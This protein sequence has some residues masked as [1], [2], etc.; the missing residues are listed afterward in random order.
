LIKWESKLTIET[1]AIWKKMHAI[2]MQSF[3]PDILKFNYR[4]EHNTLVYSIGMEI[5]K[6]LHADMD[7][8]K[9]AILLHD[10]GRSEVREGHG[11]KGAEMASEILSN[12]NFPV[13]KIIAVEYAIRVHVGWDENIP[14]TLEARILWDADKL[15]K[16]GASGILHKSMLLPLRGKQTSDAVAE[17]NSWLS[18]AEFIKNN[19]KT[20]PG[21]KLAEER[22]RVLKS[23]LQALNKEL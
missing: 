6:E 7:I 18:T 22:Y 11:Q 17:F 1:D 13:D 14:E 9:A 15:S 16:L 4:S 23:F 12:T 19:M 21:K 20:E 3:L 10:V 8:L 5:G 2:T